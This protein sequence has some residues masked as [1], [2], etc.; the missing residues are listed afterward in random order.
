MH[1]SDY[2]PTPTLSTI[3]NLKNHYPEEQRAR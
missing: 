2:K 1:H 3:K